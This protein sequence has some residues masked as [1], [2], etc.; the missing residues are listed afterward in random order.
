MTTLE[1]LY[2]DL[3]T[4]TKQWFYD[5]D[6]IDSLLDNKLDDVEVP[7]KTSDLTNDGSSSS[8][9]LVYVETS[10]TAG[11]L[12]NDGTVDT[13][14]YLTSSDIS[15]KAN[16]SDLATVATSGSYTDLDNIPSTFAPTAHTHGV[17]D[18]TD[19]NAYSNLGTS[20]NAT[21]SAIN[22]A[23]DARI[24]AL[25]EVDLLEVVSSTLPTA[26]AS[27]MNKLYM[28]PESTSANNDNYEIFVTVKTANSEYDE[29]DANSQ[30]Y[31]YAWEK[32]DTARIDISGKADVTHAHGN[33]DKD[34]KIGNNANYFVYTTTGGTVTSKQKIGNID[35]SG[36]IGSASGKIIV[37]TTDGVLTTS[38]NVTE[39]D[40]TIQS[41]ITYGESLE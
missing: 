3:K 20:A 11:L 17:G 12:K 37:T 21:Q 5:K 34:G 31:L 27:T 32:V 13:T 26:S 28:K 15:G 23:I 6:E 10:A 19:S 30:E 16:A 4:L 29:N 9:A 33:I 35:T 1:T 14:S 8:D 41:L 22:Y 38:D 18:L 25:L 40:N 2:N 36:A 7:S 24:G 39:L